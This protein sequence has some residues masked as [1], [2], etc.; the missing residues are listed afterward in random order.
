MAKK[1]LF[2]KTFFQAMQSTIPFMD[3]QPVTPRD[4]VWLTGVGL[5]HKGHPGFYLIKIIY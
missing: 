5:Y 1:R 4:G 3:A 2:A